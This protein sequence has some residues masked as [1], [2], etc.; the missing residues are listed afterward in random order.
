MRAT[1][2]DCVADALPFGHADALRV[3]ESEAKVAREGEDE[4]DGEGEGVAPDGE[5]NSDMVSETVIEIGCATVVV[6]ERVCCS[7]CVGSEAEAEVEG[8]KL[9]EVLALNVNVAESDCD[10]ERVRVSA[11][12]AVLVRHPCAPTKGRRHVQP[13]VGRI[14]LTE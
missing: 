1:L 12:E 3:R 4:G 8:E 2:S 9:A 6:A 11:M 10:V 7:G 14:P 13:H 5:K